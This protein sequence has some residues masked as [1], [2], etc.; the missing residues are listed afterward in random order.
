MAQFSK[1]PYTFI[2][3]RPAI[4]GEP[5][6]LSVSHEEKSG[7]HHEHEDNALLKGCC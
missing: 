5:L 1:R 6:P 2:S 3:G 4:L 7:T